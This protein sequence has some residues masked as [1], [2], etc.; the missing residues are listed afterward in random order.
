MFK[1]PDNIA[2]K[3][4]LNYVD[5]SEL[6][7]FINAAFLVSDA[8]L[9][10]MYENEGL[11]SEEDY[12]NARKTRALLIKTLSSRV[13]KIST[14]EDWVDEEEIEDELEYD[15]EE[16]IDR[17]VDNSVEQITY[18]DNVM[19]K[20]VERVCEK[21]VADGSISIDPDDI[22]DAYERSVEDESNL[23]IRSVVETVSEKIYGDASKAYNDKVK[24]METSTPV[25]TPAPRSSI[26]DLSE[27]KPKKISFSLFGGFKK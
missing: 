26:Y 10:S 18:D 22:R 11:L 13:N 14:P 6:V 19:D 24:T 16:I 20:I 27:D 2:I 21:I 7:G 4:F 25:V 5:D 15:K 9:K 1:V 8:E 3:E 23:I 12:Q 17:I